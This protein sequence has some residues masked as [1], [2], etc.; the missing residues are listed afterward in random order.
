[1]TTTTVGSISYYRIYE[2]NKLIVTYDTDTDSS[3][4]TNATNDYNRRKK[5]EHLRYFMYPANREKELTVDGNLY[6][7][8]HAKIMKDKKDKKSERKY[9]EFIDGF[10]EAIQSPKTLEF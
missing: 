3:A 5:Y 6:C 7:P 1:M 2:N 10:R 4:E 9:N 8:F